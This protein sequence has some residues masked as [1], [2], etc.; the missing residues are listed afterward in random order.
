MQ[1]LWCTVNKCRTCI[2]GKCRTNPWPALP[3]WPRCRNADARLTQPITGQ[4]ADAG[5]FFFLAFRHL[6]MIYQHHKASLKLSEAAYGRGGWIPL[7]RQQCRFAWCTPF[8]LYTVFENTGMPDSPTSSQSGTRMKKNA[9]ARPIPV[10]DCSGTRTEMSDSG[11]PMPAASDL[12]PMP[13]Y[14][15]ESRTVQYKR[16]RIGSISAPFHPSRQITQP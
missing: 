16:I 12:M 4:N 3:D 15:N 14:E 1:S 13:I 8:P 9:D 5:L 6:Y 10:L 2:A 11:R 7:H